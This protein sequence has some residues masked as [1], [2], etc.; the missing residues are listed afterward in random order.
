MKIRTWLTVIVA[1][2]VMFLGSGTALAM[3]KWLSPLMPR[4]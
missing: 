3:P 2:A 4:W 1:V